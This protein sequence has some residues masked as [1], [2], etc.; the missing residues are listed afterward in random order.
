MKTKQELNEFISG[1]NKFIIENP[2][3]R[4]GQAIFNYAATI[5]RD[6]TDKSIGTENDCFYSDERITNFLTYLYSNWENKNV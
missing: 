5:R 2:S 4:K 1:M 6:L 3:Y